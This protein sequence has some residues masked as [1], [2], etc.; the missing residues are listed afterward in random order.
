MAFV[1]RAPFA[2]I[3][4]SM[5]LVYFFSSAIFL[6]ARCLHRI[7]AKHVSAGA[8]LEQPAGRSCCAVCITLNTDSYAQLNTTEND[9]IYFYISHQPQALFV[10][11]YYHHILCVHMFVVRQAN[12]SRVVR[13]RAYNPNDE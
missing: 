13:E 5:P 9:V 6:S 8:F 10:V 7:T 3:C 11:F 2:G 1:T 12:Q 4:F